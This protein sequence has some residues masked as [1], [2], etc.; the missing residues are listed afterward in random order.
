MEFFFDVDGVI[1]DFERSMVDFVRDA[2]IPE[3]PEDYL[4]QS[5]EMNGEFD[6]LDIVEVWERFIGSDRLSQLDSLVET[7]S[8][9][10]LA[11][12]YPV[13][14]ITNLPNDQYLKRQ[15]NLS[16][17]NLKYTDMYFAGH[18]DYGLKDYPT[19][20]AAIA[21]LH[22]SDKRLVFLDDHPKNCEEVRS[23]FPDSDVF[24]MDR[25]HNRKTEDADWIR[26][27]DWKDFLQKAL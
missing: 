19:K 22:K 23:S 7:D 24:L 11:Q 10:D 26:V 3:L 17:H 25:P 6:N 2:Y 20:S 18:Y 21:K 8:F 5:W 15:K 16:M 9:N 4:P 13:Y 12:R 1:L 27:A 14:L